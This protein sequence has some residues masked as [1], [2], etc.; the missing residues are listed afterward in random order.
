MVTGSMEKC[1]LFNFIPKILKGVRHIQ[2][3]KVHNQELRSLEYLRY[4]ENVLIA[5]S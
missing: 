4:Q 3:R 2:Q 5:L 1:P